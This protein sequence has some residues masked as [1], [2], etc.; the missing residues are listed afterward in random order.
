MVYTITF[1]P[2]LDY[3]VEMDKFNQGEINTS[4]EEI[5]S[6]GGKGINVS[7]VLK[8]LGIENIAIS[9]VADFTGEKLRELLRNQN[10]NTD[11]INVNNGMTRINV[12]IVSDIETAINGN[13]PQISNKN[14]EELFEKLENIKEDDF[15]VLSGSIPKHLSKQIYEEIC[16]RLKNKKIKI[17]VDARKQLLT[18]ILKYK[19]FLIKPNKEELEEIF[20]VKLN[21]KEDIVKYAT[22]L[23]NMGAENVMIS[24][25][26][27]GAILVDENNQVHFV[28]VPPG[29]IVKT[30]GSGD[31]TVAGFIKRVY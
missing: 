1:N 26:S 22:E 15:L 6:P 7:I 8:N 13:G 30:V 5:L 12:K 24:L 27:D 2:A 28:K 31:S 4:K 17:I 25:G 21:E 19:P 23:K 14:I 16:E 11:F 29:I 10:I 3:A 9:F 18:N 20:N